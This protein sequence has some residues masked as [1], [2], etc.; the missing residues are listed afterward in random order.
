MVLREPWRPGK[1]GRVGA[2]PPPGAGPAVPACLD[3]DAEAE[4]EAEAV[5]GTD[6]G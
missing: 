1:V 3:A 6:E 5:L 2:S 4:A